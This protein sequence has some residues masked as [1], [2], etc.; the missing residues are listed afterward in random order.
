MEGSQGSAPRKQGL[1]DRVARTSNREIQSA[2]SSITRLLT[3]IVLLVVVLA[4]GLIYLGQATQTPTQTIDKVLPNDQ[5]P[6]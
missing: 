6:R 5:F 3:F 4:G 2:M 1:K